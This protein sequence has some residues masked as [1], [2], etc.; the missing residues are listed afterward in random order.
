MS[1]NYII[2][3]II[4]IGLAG[5]L[6]FL[7]E[8]IPSSEI[9]PDLLLKEIHDPARFITVDQVAD[10]LIKEDPSL[11]LVDVRG[12]EEVNAYTLPGALSIP[13]VDIL[14]PEWQNYL[15]QD[16]MDVVFFSNGDVIADQ[17]WVFCKRNGYKNMYVLSGGLNSWFTI[18]MQ[19][20]PPDETA[21]SEAFDRYAFRI[22]AKKKLKIK[23]PRHI[24]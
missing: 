15:D 23:T 20:T 11:L 6:L 2:L 14:K 16:V 3:A 17:A 21:P 7:S 24:I 5:G 18:I 1:R 22:N 10:R 19:P 4:L 12:A 13:L 9:S 8:N